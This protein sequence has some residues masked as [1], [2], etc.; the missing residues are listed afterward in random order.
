MKD[1]INLTLYEKLS[2]EQVDD[3]MRRIEFHCP[4]VLN[5]S[6]SSSEKEMQVL[7]GFR[8]VESLQNKIEKHNREYIEWLKYQKNVL[9]N[10]SKKHN[11]VLLIYPIRIELENSGIVP[12]E[13]FENV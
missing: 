2:N 6:I 4:K 7:A 3:Y 12:A 9:E 13:S 8:Y 10:F 5:D 11:E 1:C